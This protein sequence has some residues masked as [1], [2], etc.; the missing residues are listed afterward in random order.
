MKSN[1]LYYAFILLF[2]LLDQI[3]KTL[4]A[5]HFQIYESK[6]IISGFFNI[7][8]IRNKGA[9]FGFF[10]H[11]DGFVVYALL[12]LASFA[13]LGLVI[14][15][16]IHTPSSQIFL[17]M[18]LSLILA[19][20]VGN[21]IDRVFRGSVIDFL[22]FYFKDWHFPVFNVADSCITVGAMLLI[23]IFL[24]KKG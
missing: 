4:I 9:I 13:A 20:A 19:G 2:L 10:S 22:D 16:F 17:K 14:Y 11:I 12:T 21:L 7:T 15:Y 5:V 18:S 3:S 6:T 8:H 24:F 23:F 1:A